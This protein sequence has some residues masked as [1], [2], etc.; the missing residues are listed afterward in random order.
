MMNLRLPKI[1]APTPQGQIQQMQHYLYQ[2]VNDIQMA[3]SAIDAAT[4]TGNG[5]QLNQQQYDELARKL[6]MLETEVE[7]LKQG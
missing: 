7:A 3:F 5:G 4:S 2:L 6:K 1:D